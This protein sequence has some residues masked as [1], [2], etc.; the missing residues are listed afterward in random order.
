M[1]MKAMSAG[2]GGTAQA[3]KSAQMR[4]TSNATNSPTPH[5]KT[6]APVTASAAKQNNPMVSVSGFIV[7]E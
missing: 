7:P 1:E 6:V 5:H 3:K 2:M 4:A